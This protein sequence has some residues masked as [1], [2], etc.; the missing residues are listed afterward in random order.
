M[1]HLPLS[2]SLSRCLKMIGLCRLYLET[3][4]VNTHVC[5][6]FNLLMYNV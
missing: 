1:P 4:N 3:L 2:R 5:K 6:K